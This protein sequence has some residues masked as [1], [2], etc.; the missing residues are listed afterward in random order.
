M[1]K[2][3]F[4]I[5][6]GLGPRAT[7]YDA[8]LFALAHASSKAATFVLGKPHIGEVFLFSDSSAA[9]SSI[10]DPSTHPGQRCSLLF[11]KNVKDMFAQHASLR[12]TVRWSPGH[13]GIIGNEQAD[14]L[15][16]NGS[17]LP[18]MTRDS[19]YSHLKHRA[20]MRAQLLW[21]RQWAEDTP[22]TG[23]FALADVT[24]PSISKH[25]IYFFPRL[26]GVILT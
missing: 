18:S 3:V 9:L 8:E 14:T 25:A 24:R 11:R 22:K 7:V 20:R 19:T 12:I 26:Y 17:K 23:S 1:G 21:R 5:S 16:K 4:S 13:S 10:F 15:A 6:M 2:K